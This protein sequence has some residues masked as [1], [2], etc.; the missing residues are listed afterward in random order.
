MAWA[1]LNSRW[2]SRFQAMPKTFPVSPLVPR[3][4]TSL[5]TPRDSYGKVSRV[6]WAA[7]EPIGGWQAVASGAL[8]WQ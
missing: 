1:E 7:G 2:S 8:R 5:F 3:S 4:V 6:R